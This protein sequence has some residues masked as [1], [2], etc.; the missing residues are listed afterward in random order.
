MIVILILDDLPDELIRV[1]LP[2]IEPLH[3]VLSP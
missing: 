3:P 1:N 2:V